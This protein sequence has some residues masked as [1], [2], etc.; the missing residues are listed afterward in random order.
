MTQRWDPEAYGRHAGFVPELGRSLIDLLAPR[1]GER[2]LDLGCGRGDLA[3][4]LAR[5]EVRVV[6]V[7]GSMAMVEAARRNGIDARWVDAHDLPFREE[8][9]GVLSNAALHWMR[10]DPD[11]VI[12]SVH[13]ALVRGGRFVAEFGGAGNVADIHRA[14]RAEVAARGLDPDRIDPWFFP[15]AEEYRAR[16]EFGGFEV[17]H[18]EIFSR[19]TPLPT[20]V[21]GWLDTFGGAFFAAL[22]EEERRPARDRV[23][24]RLVPTRRDAVQGWTA[25]YVRIRFRARRPP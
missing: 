7:D 6:G 2:V 25:D 12:R 24:E 3:V 16:L 9:D 8:F 5:R 23:I 13:R 19:P 17:E 4:E 14:L 11:A 18:L 15:T 10:R 21:E 20:G 1:P 22:P